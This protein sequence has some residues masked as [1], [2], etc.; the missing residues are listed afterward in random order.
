VGYTLSIDLYRF[1]SDS[2]GCS[3]CI[4]LPN[5]HEEFHLPPTGTEEYNFIVANIV[6]CF[7]GGTFFGALMGYPLTERFG[8]IPTLRV[9]SLIFIV[10]SAMQV[11][12]YRCT[13]DY[14]II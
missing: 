14:S 11:S 2:Q 4:T 3:G 8:R 5:F 12:N 9:A 7:Q 13:Y 10:G 1:V 6:S